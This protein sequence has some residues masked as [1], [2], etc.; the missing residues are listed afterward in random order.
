MNANVVSRAWMNE[1]KLRRVESDARD[2]PFQFCIWVVFPVAEDGVAEV[3]HVHAHLM[4]AAGFET[5][6]HDSQIADYSSYEQWTLEGRTTA[7]QRANRV[8]KRWLADH[9]ARHPAAQQ[10]PGSI[11]PQEG[12]SRRGNPG[13]DRRPAQDRQGQGHPARYPPASLG[14]TFPNLGA[15]AYEE[16]RGS[17]GGGS[18]GCW[19][20]G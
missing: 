15:E 5:A 4:R 9:R 2:S 17:S 16:D 12:R 8:W 7:E 6:F 11:D 18:R 13:T 3:F 1:F 20:A 14:E 19:A 10:A